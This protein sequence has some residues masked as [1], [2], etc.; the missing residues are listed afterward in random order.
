MSICIIYA[1]EE[2]ATVQALDAALRAIGWD[3]WWDDYL[4]SDDFPRQIEEHLETADC[5]LVVWSQ[6]AVKKGWVREEARYVRDKGT[7]L[8]Q[9]RVDNAV[10]PLGFGQDQLIEFR[11]WD[12]DQNHK[13]FQELRKRLKKIVGDPVRMWS[14][15]RKSEIQIGTR[16]LLLPSFF[17]SVSSHETQLRP[18]AAIQALE[19]LETKAVLVS[20][21][22]LG[23][24]TNANKIVSS[25][26]R[27]RGKGSVVLLDS[28]NYEAYRKQDERWTEK[29]FRKTLQFNCFDYAFC[30]DRLKPLPSIN[31]NVKEIVDRVGQDQTYAAT[32]KILPIVH[33][34]IASKGKFKT[35]VAPELFA[36][37]AQSL[38]PDLIAVPERELGD[39]MLEKAK[40]V[41]S[42]RKQLNSLGWYQPIHLL[43]TGNPLSIAIFAAAGADTFDGLEWCRTIADYETALLYHF[44]QYDF[45][46]YQTRGATNPIVR[47]SADSEG[48]SFNARVAFHNLEFF[49]VWEKDLQQDIEKKRIA[50]L[51]KDFL[52]GE[53]FKELVRTLPELFQ[54]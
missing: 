46:R 42:I 52:P 6:H 27:M 39:G 44:Q 45:F 49:S 33:I 36:R 47:R 28:G 21:Y 25:L 9:I 12:G 30:F 53:F 31:G 40:V 5:V 7:P 24:T 10:V 32:G 14:G 38:K 1:R 22:D 2:K 16:K 54:S 4:Q 15:E 48:I 43:G 51:L 41:W 19:I 11:N 37:V 17:R 35:D 29:K 3:V 23:N 13:D 34:P 26:G 8:L 18:D 50:R 20:A